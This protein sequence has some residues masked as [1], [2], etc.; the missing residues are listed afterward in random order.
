[1]TVHRLVAEHCRGT[2]DD[3]P[4]ENLSALTE[5][6]EKCSAA[7]RRAEAAENELRETIVIGFLAEKI[8]QEYEGVI[9]GVTNFGIFVQ[10][11]KF[12]IDGLV[13]LDDLGDDWWEVMPRY[14]QVKGERTGK[15]YR[16]GDIMNVRIARASASQRMLDLAPC[17]TAKPDRGAKPKPGR[18]KKKQAHGKKAGKAG[19]ARQSRKS[20]TS[21]K[22]KSAKRKRK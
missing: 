15:T 2:L 12:L 20:T 21:K 18:G 22:R 3:R 1:M 7:A 10:L 17:Q 13:R 9:T 8:G 19:A 11:R 6:G 14:A 16:I 5:L 4:P